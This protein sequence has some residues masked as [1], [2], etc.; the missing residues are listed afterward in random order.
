VFYLL[1][2]L[3]K[4]RN[5]PYTNTLP[6]IREMTKEEIYEKANSVI[7]IGGMTGNERLYASGLINLFDKAK[8]ND[9]YL[10]RTILQALK[11]DE[12]SISR[13]IGYSTDSLKYPNSWDFPNENSNGLNNDNIAT[14]EY[15]NLNEIGMGAPI[16]GICNLNKKG[17]NKIII[18]KNCG[19]PAVWNE[20]GLKIAIPIWDKSFFKGTY[21]RIGVVD[22][23]KQTLTKY[24]K[25]FRVLDLRT[26]N[27]NLIKGVDSPIH[28]METVEFDINNEPI[29]TTI[30]IK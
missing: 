19:G 24:K 1:N 7:G 17:V 2:S 21:Q 13:I 15:S 3:L 18:G 29:K 20:V 25:K 5:F 8:K 27:N 4:P 9:K 28:K 12:L 6:P 16:S 14:L 10:A 11:F 22:L 30:G 26:F 23:E